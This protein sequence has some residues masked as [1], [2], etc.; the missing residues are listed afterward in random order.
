MADKKEAHEQGA[1][2]TSPH[3]Q[4]AILGRWQPKQRDYKD[5]ATCHLTGAPPP[6]CV[7]LHLM[8]KCDEAKITLL[9]DRLAC[10][11]GGTIITL[12]GLYSLFGAYK[13][14]DMWGQKVSTFFFF[15]KIQFFSFFFGHL[16]S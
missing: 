5:C 11:T 3:H 13:G 12:A 6:K 4:G 1:L 16:R 15:L 8:L 14:H 9:T 2:S 10:T 7:I